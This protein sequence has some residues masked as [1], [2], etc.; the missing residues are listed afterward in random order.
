MKP[1]SCKQRATTLLIIMPLLILSACQSLS[2]D[3]ATRTP[4][5]DTLTPEGVTVEMDVVYGPGPFNF[6]DARAGLADLSSYKSTLTLSFDGTHD[7]QPSQWSK[8]YVM[9][10][11]K[12]PAARQLTIEKSGANSDPE[13]V[14]MAEMNG[15]SYEQ[16]GESGCNANVIDQEISL[17]N[18]W[19]PAGFLTGVIG[20]DEAGGET[21][22]DVAANH[23]TFDERAFGQL[24][25]AKSTG[26]LWVATEGGYIVKYLVTTTGDATYFGEGIE[27]T[28]TWDYQLTDVNVPITFALPA[29]CPAGMV[30]APLLAD[31]TNVLN[32]PSILSYDTASSIADSAA[33]Y[34]EQIPSLGWTLVGTPSISETTALLE[35]T[36]GDQNLTVII[37]TSDG[38]TSVTI[39][40]EKTQVQ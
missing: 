22:N 37:S 20:A 27:G 33:F 36:R 17:G 9:L 24:G 28:L 6:P 8:T 10:S 21:V 38:V 4:T 18:T 14:F 23:Y 16:R 25:I 3:S 5:T 40:L 1:Y 19:E 32:M 2:G 15:A 7:G 13:A 26:E 35:F 34:Q 12:E 11:M 31:A 30:E 29:D 39:L